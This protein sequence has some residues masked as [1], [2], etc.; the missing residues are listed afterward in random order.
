MKSTPFPTLE[1]SPYHSG[2][3]FDAKGEV[4]YYYGHDKPGPGLTLEIVAEPG[5][6]VTIDQFVEIVHQWLHEI[7]G[8]LRW[9]LSMHSYC[10]PLDS[11]VDL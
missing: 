3:R 10:E 9:A 7:N 11:A 6:F 1:S 4:I 8:Q 2:E 5:P